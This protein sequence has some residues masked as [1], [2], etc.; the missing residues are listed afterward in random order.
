MRQYLVLLW[1]P[2]EPQS[3]DEAKRLHKIVRT[4]L[5]GWTELSTLP[6]LIAYVGP[7]GDCA[8]RSYALPES[9]GLIIG[10]LFSVSRNSVTNEISTEEARQ[11]VHTE[12]KHLLQNYWGNYVAIIRDVDSGARYVVRDCSGRIPCYY[13]NHRRVSIFFSSLTDIQPFG[14]RLTISDRY[15]A[16]MILRPP[17]HVRNTGLN[18]V[19]DVL[20]GECVKVSSNGVEQYSLWRPHEFVTANAIDNYSAAVSALR[21]STEN[22]VA[23]WSNVYD[24]ILLSLS[25]GLDSAIVLGCLAKLGLAKRVVC[26]NLFIPGDQSDERH[27]ARA[28]ADMAGV[29]LIEVRLT[30]DGNAF[31]DGIQGIPAQPKPDVSHL[32]RMLLIHEFNNFAH[33]HA[34]DSVWT[35]QGGDHVFLQVPHSYGATDYLLQ[36][37]VPSEFLRVTYDSSILDRNSVWSVLLTSLRYRFAIRVPEEP[38][39]ECPADGSGFLTPGVLS[40][41]GPIWEMPW[42]RYT[43]RL[44]PGKQVQIRY[45]AGLLNR[46][47]PLVGIESPFEQHPLISQPLIEAS[48]RIPTYRLQQ[49]G[50][51]RAMARDAF[52]DRVPP[53]ILQREDK[54]DATSHIRAQLRGSAP[55]QREALLDGYLCSRSIVD[56]TALEKVLLCRDTFRATE[57]FPLLC[58]LAAEMWIRAVATHCAISAEG[59]T[60]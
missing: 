41:R 16:Q 21:A 32:A 45:L 37:K 39:E 49:G 27:Y 50:R 13:I 53:C 60:V 52:A 20:A 5:P 3:E 35:G 14:L 2:K 25:G 57:M 10:R 17:L 28:A 58:C 44:P 4:K 56:R 7:D 15:L 51:H 24:R 9:A 18:E 6:G 54:G 43:S 31:F 59:C 36:H 48:L 12:G 11:I 34:C 38:P 1:S 33:A 23:A 29:P 46:H 42:K 8:M 30:A 55:L 19:S 47:R 22:T 26:I 40:T